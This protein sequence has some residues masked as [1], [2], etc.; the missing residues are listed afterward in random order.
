MIKHLRMKKPSYFLK[1]FPY[2][3]FLDQTL[4]KFLRNVDDLL[5][6]ACVRTKELLHINRL[7]Q[8]TCD[9]L[10]N[11]FES[12]RKRINI[13]TT[14]GLS[15]GLAGGILTV[16]GLAGIPFTAGVSLSLS[17]V[18]IVLGTVGGTVV[19]SGK[20]SETV[21]NKGT[22]GKLERYQNCYQE[23][24]DILKNVI[25]E[26][27]KHLMK[28]ETSS[29]EMLANPSYN[30]SEFAYLQSLPGI[31]RTVE[32]FAMIPASLLRVSAGT[33]SI[34]GAI[35]GPLTALIDVAF[36]AFTIR[37]MWKGNRTDLSENLRRLSASLH[38]SRRQ[39]HHWA[40][41]NLAEFDF[42]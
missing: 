32:G 25:G 8:K 20:I 11:E 16:I 35:V 33:L 1:K 41:G 26:L 15:S 7:L 17:V 12:R 23:R 38:A 30:G 5:E 2:S 13:A 10:I 37:N 9:D 14:T 29:E 4:M 3:F 39:L 18:G 28:L 21:L 31:I 42:H 24:L 34:I 40:Y 36:L 6:V 22:I 19:A 27:K